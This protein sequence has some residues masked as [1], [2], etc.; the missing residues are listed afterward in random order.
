MVMMKEV[1][2]MVWVGGYGEGETHDGGDGG[3]DGAAAGALGEHQ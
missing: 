3:G 1:V 2:E